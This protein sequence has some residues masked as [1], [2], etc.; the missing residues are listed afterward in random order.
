VDF[1]NFVIQKKSM[2]YLRG[3]L[4]VL[5]SNLTCN[6]DVLAPKLRME[7]LR[8]FSGVI[9]TLNVSHLPCLNK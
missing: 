8:I 9:R 4:A 3:H 7:G 1:G 5:V 6:F 2:S